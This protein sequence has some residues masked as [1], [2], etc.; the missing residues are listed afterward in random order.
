M[1]VGMPQD[2]LLHE[3]GSQI[4]FAFGKPAYHVGS[5]LKKKRKWRD[6]DVRLILSDEEYKVQGFGEPGSERESGKWIAL[7]WAFSELGKAMTGLPIDFQIQQRT[8]AN[9]AYD[10]PRSMLGRTPLRIVRQHEQAEE[11]SRR[12]RSR[13]KKVSSR[14]AKGA[15]RKKRPAKGK[16]RRPNSST[17]PKRR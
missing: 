3:F 12:V 15:G 4:W 2:I 7:C 13:A 1:S 17:T 14:S 8:H 11:L 6:V 10:E 9:K 5:S 16:T